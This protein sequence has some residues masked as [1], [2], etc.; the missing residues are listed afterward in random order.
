[1]TDGA[2]EFVNNFAGDY[3]TES[4]TEVFENSAPFINTGL[5]SVTVTEATGVVQYGSAVDLSNVQV[6]DVLLVRLSP[7][8][9]DVYNR[10]R[11]EA[12]DDGGDNVTIM[13]GSG[14]GSTF[15]ITTAAGSKWDWAIVRGN[16]VLLNDDL[17]SLA[18]NRS[19]AVVSYGGAIGLEQVR[20]GHLFVDGAG[21]EYVITA[22][23]PGLNEITLEVGVH[24]IDTTVAT[25]VDGS[26]KTN[27]NPRNLPLN[28]LRSSFG[29]EE[30]L[31]SGDLIGTGLR[32][33]RRIEGDE[34]FVWPND[35][36]V[37]QVN[38]TFREQIQSTPDPRG[39][40]TP[41]YDTTGIF[42]NTSIP[43]GSP[44]HLIAGNLEVTFVGTGIAIMHTGRI[45]ET[46]AVTIEIDGHAITPPITQPRHPGEQNPPG[47]SRMRMWS[48]A[49][50]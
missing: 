26:I 9:Q 11:I 31:F 19:T 25:Q 21:D 20:P 15:T 7:A 16:T 39:S 43:G 50:I 33:K 44:D 46:S 49:H 48:N 14:L 8:T 32:G 34:Y 12:V 45:A 37:A 27:N 5:V 10:F 42:N 22:T 4:P 2:W 28:D 47:R 17:R 24:A 41:W 23:N 18:F 35:A 13:T 6:G 30:I 38:P 40:V 3:F 36:R 1:M 29:L